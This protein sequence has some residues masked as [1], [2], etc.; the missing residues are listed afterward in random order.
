MTLSTTNFKNNN[1]K[2]TVI[3]ANHVPTEKRI[4]SL[5]KICISE[6]L[7]RLKT[8]DIKM[9]SVQDKDVMPYEIP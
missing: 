9:G 8:T 3:S 1:P 5:S 2:E 7:V 4:K 6:T